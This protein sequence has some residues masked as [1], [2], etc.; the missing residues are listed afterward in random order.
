MAAP[1]TEA[2]PHRVWRRCAGRRQRCRTHRQRCLAHQRSVV[3]STYC[4]AHGGDRGRSGLRPGQGD[5]ALSGSPRLPRCRLPDA[6]QYPDAFRLCTGAALAG[7]PACVSPRRSPFADGFRRRRTAGPAAAGAAAD[8]RR[9]R[10]R[11]FGCRCRRYLASL[12]GRCPCCVARG[13]IRRSAGRDVL[14]QPARR[15]PPGRSSGRTVSRCRH[16]AD[17]EVR[18]RRLRCCSAAHGR[19]HVTR[20]RFDTDRAVI[21]AGRR[22]RCGSCRRLRR[23]QRSGARSP[24]ARRRYEMARWA[25]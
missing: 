2:V 3:A 1:A 22:C 12:V 18:S 11:R 20:C 4:R 14:G 21:G 16:A 7:C 9:R 17:R 15:G 8:H 25:A 19:T 23:R 5:P 24:L 10:R 13:R 6:R